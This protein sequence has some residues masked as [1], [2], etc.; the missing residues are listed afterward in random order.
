MES[1]I[2]VPLLLI[3]LVILS[4]IVFIISTLIYQARRKQW[5][6]FTVTLLLTLLLGLG[7]ITAI[8]YWTVWFINPNLRRKR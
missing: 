5:I 6:W 4:L 1:L 8:I 7:L 3:M 2:T